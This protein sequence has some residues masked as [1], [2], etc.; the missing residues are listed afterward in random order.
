MLDTIE[1][2]TERKIN[3]FKENEHEIPIDK[4]FQLNLGLCLEE[5]MEEEGED[6]YW[7]ES[8]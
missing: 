6:F 3:Q 8:L 4:I 5:E 1:N 2:S 7:D